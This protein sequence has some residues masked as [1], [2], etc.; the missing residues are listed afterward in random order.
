MKY[1]Y[2]IFKN[3]T[4][5]KVRTSLT[6]LSIMVAF[7][8]FGLLRS[9]SAAFDGGAQIAGEDRL[10]T[11]HKYPLFNRYH[12]AISPRCKHCPA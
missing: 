12:K 2:F 11:I 7:L 5:K 8:L 3:L 1:V 10:V 4:R 9:L 6:I